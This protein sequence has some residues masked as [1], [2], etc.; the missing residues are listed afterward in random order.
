VLHKQSLIPVLLKRLAAADGVKS[1]SVSE[2]ISS[3]PTHVS[4][5]TMV[6]N[7]ATRLACEFQR[8]ERR[9]HDEHETPT[10]G[11]KHGGPVAPRVT[12][13]SAIGLNGQAAKDEVSAVWRGGRMPENISGGPAGR[14]V[15]HLTSPL[16]G[17]LARVKTSLLRDARN[18]AR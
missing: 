17:L 3:K 5:R 6:G 11:K 14:S 12:G 10:A 7:C 2:Q 4:D 9:R 1:L 16:M 8:T 13:R 15:F 18:I